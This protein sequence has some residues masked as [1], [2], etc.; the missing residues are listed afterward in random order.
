V[1]SLRSVGIT[2]YSIFLSSILLV[3][4]PTS[5]AQTAVF[6][7]PRDYVVGSDPAPLVIADFNGDGKADI[8]KADLESNTVS[9]LLQNA[10]GSFQG[11]V[12]Y[13]VGGGPSSIQ[14]G[15]VNGDR[16]LDLLFINS[17]D[18]TLGILLGNGDGTF[19]PEQVVSLPTDSMSL[20][21][22]GDFNGDRKLDFAITTGV[23]VG[24]YDVA[25]SIGNGDGTFQA[26]VAY[27]LPTDSPISLAAADFNN[28]GVLDLV[29]ACGF[30]DSCSSISVLLGNRDGSFQTA[31]TTTVNEITAG[32]VLGD[33]NHDGNLDIAT[34]TYGDTYTNLTVLTGNGDGTF[35]VA[36]LPLKFMPLAAGDLNGDGNPDLVGVPFDG[37]MME[38][39]MNNGDGTFAVALPT[40]VPLWWSFTP[41]N[42]AATLFDLTG[43]QNVDLVASVD[44]RVVVVYGNDGTFASFPSF[45]LNNSIF[46]GG[47]RLAAA[48]FNSDG[49]Q[50]VAV[51]L[52]SYDKGYTTLQLGIL[53]NNGQGFSEISKTQI[54]S[55]LPSSTEAYVRTADL[56]GDGHIDVVIGGMSY[57]T[58]AGENEVTIHH[59][60]SP[61]GDAERS[62]LRPIFHDGSSEPQALDISILLAKGDGTFQPPV[63]YGTQITGPIEIGDFNGDGN[64]DVVAY[65][66]ASG[67]L[68]V[69]PGKG[70]GTF[71]SQ[72]DS[73]LSDACTDFRV[74]DFNGDGKLDLAASTDGAVEIFFGNGDGTFASAQY[75]LPTSSGWQVYGFAL[76]DMNG[77]GK[78]DLVMGTTDILVFLGNGDGTFQ[79]PIDN[80][81]G[82]AAP[83]VIADFN[84]D[85][86]ADVI[87]GGGLDV[88]FIAGNGDGTLRTPVHFY[89]PIL[90]MALASADF[91]GNGSLD[92][93]T[94][95]GGSVSLLLNALGNEA[96]AAVLIPD[97]LSFGAVPVGQSTATSATLTYSANTALRIIG[98]KISGAQSSDFSQA[99]NCGTALAAGMSCS[100]TITFTPTVIGG[101][102][103]SF[104]IADSAS[105][106]PQIISLSGTGIGIGLTS[107]SNSTTAT[108]SAGQTAKYTLWIGAAGMSGS[109]SLTCTGIP[110]QAAC[111]VPG[112][113]TV[114]ATTASTVSVSVATTAHSAAAIDHRTVP[115]RGVWATF[116]LGGVFVPLAWKKRKT[117]AACLG[118]VLGSLILI[119]SC[120]GSSTTS[121]GGGGGTPAGTYALTVTATLNSSKQ[122]VN[123]TLIVQ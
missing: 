73:A 55:G 29:S 37:G 106:T 62:E 52:P 21:A 104:Q 1:S 101:R 96:P 27:H 85:G 49:K 20:L 77:D 31:T 90:S 38:A 43:S 35:S 112:S 105:N 24:Q 54:Q 87:A 100:I 79:S 120:G 59:R 83:I 76:G 14:Q 118:M 5:L 94:S 48:D 121:T 113:V 40:S 65:D 98:I 78:L 16:K 93:V 86:K 2:L 99:N 36:V 115:L 60:S 34:S 95:D 23:Q 69:L 63:L 46:V 28:D 41:I 7:G 58:P 12:F 13:S 56:N 97:T 107:G 74:A 114:D 88:S 44:D 26:P 47:A 119:S 117:A 81:I 111:S 102:S 19:Q 82:G 64:L 6:N 17:T 61:T 70:D 92:V 53:L 66:Q 3:F 68:A 84:L 89:T 71:G 22:V 80:S 39:L 72:I 51:A 9:V 18:K 109:A 10:D 25:V 67:S 116:L 122:S 33:F 50:D 103:A 57:S 15:D 30:S 32:I 4:S 75:Y 108:V 91:D 45:P 8:A 110:Q 123:L 11:P 42:V